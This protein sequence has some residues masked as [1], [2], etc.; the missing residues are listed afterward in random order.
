MYST[1]MIVA[2]P[3]RT[4]SV[5]VRLDSRIH[6]RKVL[7]TY[8]TMASTLSFN[9]RNCESGMDFTLSEASRETS[10]SRHSV[11]RS[12]CIINV[13]FKLLYRLQRRAL[14]SSDACGMYSNSTSFLT[15][16][17]SFHSIRIY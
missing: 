12:S 7:C 17:H 5:T 15:S 13:N 16:I 9:L 2:L 10:S 3:I 8:G 14:D 1:I 4:N 6:C 11:H